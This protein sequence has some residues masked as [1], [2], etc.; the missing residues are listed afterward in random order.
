MCG[1]HDPGSWLIHVGRLHETILF[2]FII[3]FIPSPHL[4]LLAG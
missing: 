2:I 4:S 1:G 3:I